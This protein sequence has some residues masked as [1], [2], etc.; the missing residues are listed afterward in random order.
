MTSTTYSGGC[1]CGAIRFELDAPENLEV[2]DCN[3]SICRRSGYLHLFVPES[4]FRLVQGDDQLVTYQFNTKVARH[5]FCKTCGIKSFYV[6]RSHPDAFSVNARCLDDVPIL[7]MKVTPFDGANWEQ[8]VEQLTSGLSIRSATLDDAPAITEIYNEAILTTTATFDIEPKTVEDREVWLRNRTDRFPVLVAETGSRIV[9]WAAL[10][11]FSERA[12][13]DDTAESA[14]YVHSSYR[15][16]G[17][18]RQLKS[19]I[20]DEAR[21]HGFHSLIVRVTADSAASLHLNR[22]MGF[23]HIGTLREAGRKFGRLLDVHIMQKILN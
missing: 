23:V 21:R 22:D 20:T 14:L 4:S 11:P 5:F 6:P 16:K 8:N 15:G 18:G 1:H 10:A 2:F 3:C 7:S 13:Y 12:G 9:G 17:I 19:R